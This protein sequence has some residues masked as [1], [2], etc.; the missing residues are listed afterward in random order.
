MI[1]FKFHDSLEG[2]AIGIPLDRLKIGK[3]YLTKPFNIR[4]TEA[5]PYVYRRY[6]KITRTRSGYIINRAGGRGRIE[7]PEVPFMANQLAK[8]IVLRILT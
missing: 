4:Y 3:T 1:S 6:T 5:D 2:V 8:V 7:R